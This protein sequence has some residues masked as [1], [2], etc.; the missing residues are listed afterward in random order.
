MKKCLVAYCIEQFPGAWS[1]DCYGIA[2]L[3]AK[4]MNISRACLLFNRA[5]ENPFG[6]H[7]ICIGL[8]GYK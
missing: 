5:A 7:E 6:H 3:R 1:K 4:Q 2:G 8:A